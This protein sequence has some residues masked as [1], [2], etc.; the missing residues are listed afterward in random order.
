MN[1]SVKKVVLAVAACS[2]FASATSAMADTGS[3]ST[4]AGQKVSAL[5][6]HVI[7]TITN[8]T[9][10]IRPYTTAG[11]DATTLNMG[12]I[13]KGAESTP[14]SFY[15]KPANGCTDGIIGSASNTTASSAAE[16]TWESNGLTEY[17]IS[18]MYGT[19]KNVHVELSPV[20][21]GDGAEINSTTSAV[22]NGG[23][24]KTGYQTVQYS[25]IIKESTVLPFKYNVK[26]A[27]DDSKEMSAGT[28]DTDMSYTVAYK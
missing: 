15:L 5:T 23:L 19:A 4:P 2:A 14:V 13:T 9:C 20:S 16:I 17:G 26:F 21:G 12:V 27:S 8:T 3:P 22:K 25:T 6:M 28:V 24:I 11:A 10:D 7:G 18:N 1:T